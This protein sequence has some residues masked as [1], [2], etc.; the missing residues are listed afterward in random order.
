M[1]KMSLNPVNLRLVPVV[2]ALALMCAAGN[3]FAAINCTAPSASSSNFAYVASTNNGS[4][5]QSGA[6]NVV[7]NNVSFSCTRTTANPN[8]VQFGVTNGGNVSGG[9]NRARN[10]GPPIS[11]ISYNTY[12]DAGCSSSAPLDDGNGGG[13]I[14]TTLVGPLN[15]PETVNI[16]FYT[17]VTLNQALTSFPAGIYTD[18]AN[19]N[20][21]YQGG[22]SAIDKT[23][24]LSVNINAPAVCSIGSLPPTINLTYTAFQNTA[25]FQFA[26]FNAQCTNLLPYTMAV[27][28]AA[29]VVRGVNYQLGLSTGSQGGAGSI[30]STPLSDVGGSTGTKVHFI[31]ASM[32]AG[33]AG[34]IGGATSNIH[35]LTIT[36]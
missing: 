26:Q 14:T 10:A 7:T 12:K 23:T 17:C 25:A 29:G 20:V 32:Q 1:K 28:P 18:Q 9:S 6:N 22:G 24:P 33:Q 13:R 35:T 31:N 5:G 3:S 11:F 16:Q 19:M 2:S 4:P 21:R 15:T 34:Q 27:S 30:G 36:Y 8:T